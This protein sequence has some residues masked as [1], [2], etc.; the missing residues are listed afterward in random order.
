[1]GIAAEPPA[2]STSALFCQDSTL[3]TAA[4][5]AFDKS[6]CRRSPLVDEH[7]F[8]RSARPTLQKMISLA[9]PYVC[10]WTGNLLSGLR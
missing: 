3:V 10:H 7:C 8:L 2:P 4:A 1:M 5:E 6:P 9:V